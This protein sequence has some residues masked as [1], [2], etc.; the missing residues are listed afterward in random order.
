MGMSK[1]QFTSEL[2][3][4][5]ERLGLNVISDGERTNLIKVLGGSLTQPFTTSNSGYRKLMHSIHKEH[6]LNLINPEIP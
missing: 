5:K 6:A 3:S 4:V 1:E 2:E